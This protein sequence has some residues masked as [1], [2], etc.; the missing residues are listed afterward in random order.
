MAGMIPA[1]YGPFCPIIRGKVG[2]ATQPNRIASARGDGVAP[3]FHLG[4]RNA[5]ECHPHGPPMRLGNMRELGVHEGKQLPYGAIAAE[6]A[7]RGHVNEGGRPYAA[8]SI[9]N[10]VKRA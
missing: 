1:S 8:M 9:Y 6:M 4:S 2:P 7:K 10:M 3:T 5:P